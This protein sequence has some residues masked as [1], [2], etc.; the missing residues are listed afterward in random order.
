MQSCF[1]AIEAFAVI[2]NPLSNSGIKRFLR[3]RS[4]AEEPRQHVMQIAPNVPSNV[5]SKIRDE[6]LLQPLSDEQGLQVFPRKIRLRKR[7]LIGQDRWSQLS[8]PQLT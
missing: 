4:S 8:G 5:L 1:L 2:L 3:M 6:Q 7:F